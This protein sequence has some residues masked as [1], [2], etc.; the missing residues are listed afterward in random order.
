MDYLKN[1]INTNG[2][3]ES[4]KNGLIMVKTNLGLGVSSVSKEKI[5][6]GDYQQQRRDV[7]Q[8]SEANKI[9]GMSPSSLDEAS[10]EKFQLRRRTKC[11]SYA[12][13]YGIKQTV[14]LSFEK[15][16][17]FGMNKQFITTE[18]L[19]NEAAIIK[20]LRELGVTSDVKEARYGRLY[21][22]V[23]A[24]DY[25]DNAIALLYLMYAHYQTLRIAER[26]EKT[27]YMI[28]ISA[29]DLKPFIDEVDAEKKLD[30]LVRLVARG[31]TGAAL[32]RA[33]FGTQKLIEE[34]HTWYDTLPAARVNDGDGNMIDNPVYLNSFF[35][36]RRHV[37]EMYK[38][39]DGH[40][41]SGPTY[42]NHYGFKRGRFIVPTYLNATH[43]ELRRN[44]SA[45]NVNNISQDALVDR[46]VNA[47]GYLNLSGFNTQETAILNKML[48]G[49]LRTTPFLIDQDIDLAIVQN[50]IYVHHGPENL[51]TDCTYS[52]ADMRAIII[53]FVVNHRL[54]E[55]MQS[56][57]IAA[58]YWLAQPANET[59]ESHWWTHLPRRLSL[60]KL[61]LK[62][63]AFHFLLQGDGVAT[64][65]DAIKTL[66]ELT[67][68]NDSNILESMLANTAWYWGE[69]M[70]THNAKHIEDILQR[71]HGN[72]ADAL[73][74][75]TRADSM[76]SAMI[77]RAVP[78]PVMPG[79]FTQLEGKLRDYYTINMKFGNITIDHIADYGYV[80]GRN[81]DLILNSMAGPSGVA[82]I[83]GLGG[84]LMAGTPYSSV[85]SINPAVHQYYKGRYRKAYNYN[86]LWAN[87]VVSRWQGYTVN[88]THP[89]RN[90][91]HR[92]FAANDVS[93]AMPPVT[94]ATLDMPVSY[95]LEFVEERY[96]SFGSS[97]ESLA[98]CAVV[99]YWTR[100]ETVLQTQPLWNARA[101]SYDVRNI[102]TIRGFVQVPID[103]EKFTANILTTYDLA[104]ADFQVQEL[105]AGV[106]MPTASG[107][108]NLLEPP[109]EARM[110]DI[111]VQ[112]EREERPPDEQ[113]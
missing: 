13:V 39:N 24:A 99:C 94:P 71:I 88:Y 90:G 66:S 3:I 32:P 70:F 80:A 2:T 22:A 47:A 55:D 17:Y 40:S 18:G 103:S 27:D 4:F 9:A 15:H 28:R 110:I 101:A 34:I 64:S 96:N 48:C 56:A 113:D 77:G 76:F 72:N 57:I 53:K 81:N 83:T 92:I 102:N 78:K 44:L 59:V 74:A 61:G 16:S 23:F 65:V 68:P 7:L 63:A 50:S 84:S 97:F 87:G 45:Y 111:P 106:P 79:V 82:L 41:E 51:Y 86:D 85:F 33:D 29:P 105:I 14:E 60:P 112:T 25:Y 49:N 75:S 89:L 42:G 20:R 98:D 12:T 6:V 54:H 30:L 107:S 43:N 104:L 100:A 38:Y 62:R 109:T 26:M 91:T 52:A 73:D 19:P 46:L 58:K 11:A 21:N 95:Q 93:I 8:S 36:N 69:Y 10:G 108:A 1:I 31:N 67:R 35:E 37:W 5:H